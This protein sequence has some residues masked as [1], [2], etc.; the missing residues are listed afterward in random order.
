MWPRTAKRKLAPNAVKV[1][2]SIS[3]RNGNTDGVL[4]KI[5]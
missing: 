5:G 2:T 3:S 4:M 1:S